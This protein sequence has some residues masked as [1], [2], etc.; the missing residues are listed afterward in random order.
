[1]RLGCPADPSLD[2]VR[3]YLAKSRNFRRITTPKLLAAHDHMPNYMRTC[4]IGRDFGRATAGDRF[5]QDL[6]LEVQRE[7][8]V[9]SARHSFLRSSLTGTVFT[10]LS[11]LF[12]STF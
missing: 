8:E 1:M 2:E 11:P 5:R 9:Q 4:I 7:S 12:I 10:P 3:D 6:Q